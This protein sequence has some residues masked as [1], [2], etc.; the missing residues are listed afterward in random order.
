SCASRK[1]CAAHG[2][3]HSSKQTDSSASIWGNKSAAAHPSAALFR[4]GV[5]NRKGA[6]HAGW[7]DS[8]TFRQPVVRSGGAV[9]RRG[10]ALRRIPFRAGE[11]LVAPARPFPTKDAFS[12]GGNTRSTI[13][14]FFVASFRGHDHM[15]EALATNGANH[16]LDIGSLPRRA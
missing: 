16:P 7:L 11:L 6:Q 8:G 15:I 3:S 4:Q 14:A 2:G 5:A 13:A 12:I 10:V 1:F 9:G